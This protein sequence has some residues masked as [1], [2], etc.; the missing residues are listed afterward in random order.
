MRAAAGGKQCCPISV[1]CYW[2]IKS[3]AV[4]EPP[5]SVWTDLGGGAEERAALEARIT[6]LRGFAKG[7]HPRVCRDDAGVRALML[8]LMPVSHWAAA[9]ATLG[10]LQLNGCPIFELEAAATLLLHMH[11]PVHLVLAAEAL[12]AAR[13]E[14]NEAFWVADNPAGRLEK[15]LTACFLQHAGELGSQCQAA[16]PAD[17]P[18]LLGTEY[19]P[20]L[21]RALDVMVYATLGSRHFGP[22]L[23]CV[24][25]HT[26]PFHTHSPMS[27][28]G[29]GSSGLFASALLRPLSATEYARMTQV[30]LRPCFFTDW[31]TRIEHLLPLD[32]FL[33]D[34]AKAA[35]ELYTLFTPKERADLRALPTQ[36]ADQE[37]Q[38]LLDDTRHHLLTT[39][40][41]VDDPMRLVE[42]T[43]LATCSC[44]YLRL[45]EVFCRFFYLPFGSV[46]ARVHAALQQ[47]ALGPLPWVRGA[48]RRLD[49]VDIWL[50]A[51]LLE[52]S[53][54]DPTKLREFCHTH[55]STH[56]LPGHADADEDNEVDSF[57]AYL[58]RRWHVRWPRAA[59]PLEPYDGPHRRLRR[60]QNRR[61]SIAIRHHQDKTR[62]QGDRHHLPDEAPP[63]EALSDEAMP[64]ET[65]T[66]VP[67][68]KMRR[69]Q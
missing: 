54:V 57:G 69:M 6:S 53:R 32:H 23:Q 49:H 29:V 43:G 16:N 4:K 26:P 33:H 7:W 39:P 15:W 62:A 60:S 27:A 38:A 58:N 1:L 56:G 59:L 55:F 24:R 22:E 13:A 46:T 66:A 52:R 30:T 48:V 31:V 44:K 18:E 36:L 12:Q 9:L 25:E 10:R 35:H 50:T 20:R 68:V 63:D 41:L 14:M 40:G 3:D 51:C 61:W 28:P 45:A 8:Q 5:S 64:Q 37:R 19:Q 42:E 47:A 17:P 34:Q 2:A 21:R 65:P 11:T 67:P